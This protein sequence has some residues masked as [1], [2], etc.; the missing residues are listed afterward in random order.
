MY[1]ISA[2]LLHPRAEDNAADLRR[3][4]ELLRSAAAGPQGRLEHHWI[5]ST[6]GGCALVLYLLAPTL[7]QAEHTAGVLLRRALAGEPALDD[8]VIDQYA[9]DLPVEMLD[10]LWARYATDE[11]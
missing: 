6:P 2:R 3:I 9:A 11:L 7:E 1:V 5:Q 4:G 10:T 8:W